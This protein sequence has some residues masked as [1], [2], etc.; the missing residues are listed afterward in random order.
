MTIALSQFECLCGFRTTGE[1]RANLQEFPELEDL[2][3]QSGVD[4]T[5]LG[6]PGTDSVIQLR[7]LFGAY[8]TCPDDLA[9]LQLHVLTSRLRAKTNLSR[10]EQLVLR[11]SGEYPG[12]RGVFAA[13]L[14]NFLTLEPGQSFF[15]GANEPHAYLRGDCVEC[16]ALSDNVVRAGLTPKFKDVDT[17]CA[18]LSYR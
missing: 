3:V 18:M 13:V 15:I 9:G 14:L 17:L 16:M 1:I 12:D 7:A 6:A 10:L 5:V 11:L 8:L 2:L 4:T